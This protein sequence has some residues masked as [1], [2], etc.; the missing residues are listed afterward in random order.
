MHRGDPV[1]THY[2][3]DKYAIDF[4]TEFLVNEKLVIKL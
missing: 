3:M 2:L 1:E 4:D